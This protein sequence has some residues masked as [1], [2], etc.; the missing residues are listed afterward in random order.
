MITNTEFRTWLRTI[1]PGTGYYRGPDLEAVD[2][3]DLHVI[4]TGLAGAGFDAEQ[5]LDRP[6][7]QLRTVG[8]VGN[9]E[10]AEIF[11]TELD[12]AVTGGPFPTFIA[13][14]RVVTIGRVGG[15]PSPLPLDATNRS[16]YVC[17]YLIQQEA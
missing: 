3:P 2:D 4:V 5:V 17:S 9:K 12:K 15:A 13:G 8:V 10:D 11:A 7:V 6:G 16:N 14:K 1:K